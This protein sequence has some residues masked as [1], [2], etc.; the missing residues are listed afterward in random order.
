[1]AKSK[2]SKKRFSLRENYQ[3][4]WKH[5]G[6]SRKFIFIIA[7]IFLLF[8]VIGLFAPAPNSL[9]EWISKYIQ[10]ITEL[11]EGLSPLELVSFIFFNNLKSGFFGLIFGILVGIFP[12]FL[13]LFNGY[14]LGFVLGA[15]IE[16][17]GIWVIWK[18]LP[19]GVFELPAIFIAL[20][21]GL[22]TGTYSLFRK[23]GKFKVDFYESI[24]AFFFIVLP[25]LLIAAVIEGVLIFLV[26]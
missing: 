1:M 21:L 15:S 23:K 7:G 10:E 16:S 25:L 6:D 19:H 13:A 5:I 22:R 2:K 4:S 8:T 20:G 12:V 14:I 17:G 18:L 24:R 11:T 3:K 9:I 26:G